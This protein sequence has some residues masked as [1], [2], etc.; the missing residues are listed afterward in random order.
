MATDTDLTPRASSV[1]LILGV[2]R[3]IWKTSLK[4]S[5]L[6][7]HCRFLHFC[8]H[9]SWLQDVYLSAFLGF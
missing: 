8:H 9:P 1:S 2:P 3:Y 7:Q 5:R 4:I 6:C